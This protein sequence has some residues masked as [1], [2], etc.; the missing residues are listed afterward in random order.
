MVLD[1]KKK[2]ITL[3]LLVVASALLFLYPDAKQYYY[4]T[5]TIFGTMYSIKYEAN[6]DLGDA[7]MQ[8]LLAVDSS[9]SM[10]N[11]QSTLSRINRSESQQTDPYLRSVFAKAQ[12]VSAMSAGAFDVTVAP[13][14][15]AWG[16]GFKNKANITQ[17]LLDSLRQLVGYDKV[18]LFDDKIVKQDDRVMIDLCAIAKG[19]SCD[20]VADLLRENGCQNYLVEIGGEIVAKG[21]NE[22]GELW[23]VGISEPVDELAP[24]EMRY[25]E[26]IAG[27]S[28][29][30][31]TS[32]NYRNF[33]YD[34]SVKRAHTIDPRTGYPVNHSL[35]SA[36][37]IASDCMTADALAT[38]CMVVGTTE[39]MELIAQL[40]GVECYLISAS[41]SGQYKIT[42]TPGFSKFIKK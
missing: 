39:A 20:V 17:E 15:N 5:G 24:T 13:L 12:E 18:A 9:V 2:L 3:G 14:V 29:A 7:I 38:M 25:S 27:D 40:D 36:T 10:F 34:G 23:K 21:Q 6:E 37:V 19:F 11:P 33:Y 16:F 32:G 35:L 8:R 4:N 1:K 31:A 26:I 42:K 28:F 41:E 30:M 22:K